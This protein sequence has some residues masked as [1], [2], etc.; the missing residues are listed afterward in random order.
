MET[1]ADHIAKMSAF[2]EHPHIRPLAKRGA[3]T[4]STSD[5]M[6]IDVYV[7]ETYGAI[8]GCN[9]E[10]P[11]STRT[12]DELH[13]ILPDAA[14]YA[15]YLDSALDGVCILDVEPECPDELKE[16]FLH[17][18][19]LYAERSM[20]GKGYHLL[21][22]YPSDIMSRYPIAAKKSV[23]KDK[24]LGFEFLF[25]HWVTFT[26][27][28]VATDPTD[29]GAAFVAGEVERLAKEQVEV[30]LAD[31]DIA[32]IA[33]EDTPY[34]D[35]VLAIVATQRARAMRKGPAD[36]DGDLSRYEFAIASAVLYQ[37]RQAQKAVVRKYDAEATWSDQ[38][39]A[40]LVYC[41][42]SNWLPYRDKHD[43]Q[44]AGLPWLLYVVKNALDVEAARN[45]D[46]N[47]EGE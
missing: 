27:D 40:W 3:W 41:A 25:E 11:F 46:A 20:S 10:V 45:A 35:E 43:E 15:F 17:A 32:D 39:T 19:C 23:M 29:E 13:Q 21:M 22:P 12:L 7:L 2:V 8:A 6:P 44:R 9:R 1:L 24:G 47:V 33:P 37:V 30:N 18:G 14:N 38:Q 4:I 16:R 42:L 5:K 34:E 28:V 26:G 36:Y 31:I